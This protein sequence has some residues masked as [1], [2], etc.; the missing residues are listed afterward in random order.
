MQLSILG[1][2]VSQQVGRKYEHVRAC[3]LISWLSLVAKPIGN[4]E[5]LTDDE[6][7]KWPTRKYVKRCLRLDAHKQVLDYLLEEKADYLLLDCNDTRRKILT[8]QDYKEKKEVSDFKCCTVNRSSKC[9]DQ[10]ADALGRDNFIEV[11]P[12]KIDQ[13]L[14][15]E[16]V[17]QVC[18]KILGVYQPTEI[19]VLKHLFA[20]EYV[21][22][23]CIKK[24]DVR[25]SKGVLYKTKGLLEKCY[26]VI[27][28]RM[29][30]C[31]LI[32]FPQGVLGDTEHVLGLMPLHYNKLYFEYC[33]KAM[34]I[35]EKRY[36]KQIEETLLSQ[37]C[38]IYSNRF[39]TLKLKCEVNSKNDTLKKVKEIFIDNE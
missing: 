5:N 27:L 22:G 17:N 23:N 7:S 30:G 20:E 9:F 19:I 24:F 11:F 15:L 38:D 39:E 36:D 37:L 34:V 8:S 18:N 31:H 1:D 32:D 16:A 29:P 3:G 14:Y 21:D 33:E 4:I 26:D 2:C 28:D 6:I 25:K 35:I 12:S 10:F 13:E